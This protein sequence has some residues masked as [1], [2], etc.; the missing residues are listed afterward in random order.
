[1]QT[2]E[3]TVHILTSDVEDN[4]AQSV[5]ICQKLSLHCPHISTTEFLH[6][7][8]LNFSKRSIS[9]DLKPRLCEDERPKCT[10]KATLIIPVYVPKRPQSRQGLFLKRCS[11]VR[12]EGDCLSFKKQS[13]SED[14]LVAVAWG[15]IGDHK[16]P[17]PPY[18]RLFCLSLTTVCH[19]LWKV[20]APSFD[21]CLQW[22][23]DACGGLLSAL[24]QSP[25]NKW[26][27]H[28]R[29]SERARLEESF[30]SSK[31]TPRC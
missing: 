17:S 3:I 11:N 22:V 20:A 5:I 23:I 27:D 16:C 28:L 2:K 13:K 30:L 24:S 1:M 29:H 6:V 9:S 26:I 19:C 10:E 18:L 21:V 15:C 7:F 4:S 8:T 31:Q 25:M 12:L 14:T